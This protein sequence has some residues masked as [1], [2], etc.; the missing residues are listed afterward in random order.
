MANQTCHEASSV[1]S[2]PR[3]R[4]RGTSLSQPKWIPSPRHSTFPRSNMLS[5]RRSNV[6]TTVLYF[7]GLPHS[8]VFRIL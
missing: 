5:F 3:R 1:P 6:L 7:Q 2:P 8:F 4:S